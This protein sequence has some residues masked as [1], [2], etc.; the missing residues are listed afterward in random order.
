M[1]AISA[2]LRV[3]VIGVRSDAV[4]LRRSRCVG[5]DGH[6]SSPSG[7]GELVA[8]WVCRLGSSVSET[9]GM[10]TSRSF[11]SS[12]CSAAW[13]TTGPRMTV[14]PSWHR[15]RWSVRRTTPTSGA[16]GGPRPGSRTA[17]WGRDRQPANRLWCRGCG[18]LRSREDRTNGPGERA[19]HHVVIEDG[20]CA[21]WAR[22]RGRVRRRGGPLLGG[23]WRRAWCRCSWCGCA[24]CS[25]THAARGRSLAR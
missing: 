21:C 15:C 20:D 19:S 25:A 10:P 4:R 12:P 22:L 3:A 2:A 5:R 18:R 16:R 7:W 6:V 23:W 17:G 1:P 14:V 13:S 11:W 24:P 8:R 9:R